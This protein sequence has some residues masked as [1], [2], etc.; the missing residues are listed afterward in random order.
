M[1]AVALC[2]VWFGSRSYTLEIL[3]SVCVLE[4]VDDERCVCANTRYWKARFVYPKEGHFLVSGSV[5]FLGLP[6]RLLIELMK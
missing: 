1:K 3:T 4:I 5:L 6:H 2:V